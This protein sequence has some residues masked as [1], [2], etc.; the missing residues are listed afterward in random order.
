MNL[1]A[2]HPGQMKSHHGVCKQECFF[3]HRLA[4]Q[5]KF[6]SLAEQYVS[7]PICGSW[8]CEC[9]EVHLVRVHMAHAP[10]LLRTASCWDESQPVVDV[11]ADPT[12]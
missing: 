1:P 9:Q 12:V 3:A 10:C 4:L 8:Q 7:K 11:H 5:D 6:N 2:G